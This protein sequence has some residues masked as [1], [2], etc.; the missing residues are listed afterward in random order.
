M[1]SPL[2]KSN[3]TSNAM[4]SKHGMLIFVFACACVYR[5]ID[6]MTAILNFHSP[7]TQIFVLDVVKRIKNVTLMELAK[8]IISNQLE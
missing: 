2:D 1:T 6:F 8:S 7:I 5:I 4:E 3:Q